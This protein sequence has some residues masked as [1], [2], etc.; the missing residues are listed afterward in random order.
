[1]PYILSGMKDSD[2]LAH[3]YVVLNSVGYVECVVL[4]CVVQFLLS[5]SLIRHLIS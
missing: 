2:K 5:C 3:V 4:C 1:M